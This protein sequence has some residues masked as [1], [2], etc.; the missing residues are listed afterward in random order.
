MAKRPKTID[1]Y[2]EGL[3]PEQRA[4]LMEVRRAVLA[5]APGAEECI[6]YGMPAFRLQGKLIAGF[7][8]AADHCSYHPMSG[9]TIPTLGAKLGGYDT[10]RGTLRFAATQGLP[11][12][13]VR[14]LVLAR[15][16]EIE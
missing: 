11:T 13:V 15:I 9:A 3:A 14:Q 2:L 16:A 7:R 8:A 1:E 4:A 6:S 5:A 12:S 10:S